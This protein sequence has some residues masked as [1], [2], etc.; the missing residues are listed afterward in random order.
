MRAP[1]DGQ[2]QRCAPL[3]RGWVSYL[4]RPPFERR[5]CFLLIRGLFSLYALACLQ[6][7]AH[8][9]GSAI[10]WAESVQF[11]GRISLSFSPLTF[12]LKRSQSQSKVFLH[13]KDAFVLAHILVQIPPTEFQNLHCTTS[14]VLKN[15]L[16]S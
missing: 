2:Q 5:I 11:Y 10:P 4:E 8:P 6:L 3:Y 7:V 14:S 13:R 1:K 12:L 9:V 16:L 15:P